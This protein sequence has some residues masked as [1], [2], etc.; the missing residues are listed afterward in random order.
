M[1][2]TLEVAKK[3]QA[4]TTKGPPFG[5]IHR[6]GFVRVA[7]ASPSASTGD[8][9][10]NV[11]RSLELARQADAR[12]V[13]LAIFPELNISSYAIDDLLLQDAFLDTVEAGIARLAADSAAL[14]TLLV[15]GAPLRRN[16]RLYNTGLA[17]FPNPICPIT[18]NIMRKDGSP[19]ASASRG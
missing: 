16:G 5:A 15:V 12:G 1:T 14:K 9:G 18:A 11:D 13:D 10:F 3:A 7:A 2:E 4:K 8:V 19:R 6:H 17:S